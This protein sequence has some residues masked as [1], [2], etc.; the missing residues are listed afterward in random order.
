VTLGIRLM[1]AKIRAIT[2][3]I[4]NRLIAVVSFH[5]CGTHSGYP[6][7][8]TAYSPTGFPSDSPHDAVIGASV[9][10]RLNNTD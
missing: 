5:T 2:I 10:F 3:R 1:T 7:C 4:A 6:G 9:A 8:Y